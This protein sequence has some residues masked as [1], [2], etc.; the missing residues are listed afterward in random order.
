MLKC[1]QDTQGYKK[2]VI[3]KWQSFHVEGWGGYVHRE[4]LKHIKLA[5]KEWHLLD[6]KNI[7]RRIDVLKHRLSEL[8]EGGDAGGVV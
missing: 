6:A 5:L 2:F 8:D 1:W 4:K 3:E 7:T